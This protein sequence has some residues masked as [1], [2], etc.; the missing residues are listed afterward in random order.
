MKN[1]GV[2]NIQPLQMNTFNIKVRVENLQ[3]LQVKS[4]TPTTDI[5]NPYYK[6][7]T[8]PTTASNYV[9]VHTK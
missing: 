6:A 4:S 1:V 5:F 2:E 3:P 8:T 9:Q 7:S